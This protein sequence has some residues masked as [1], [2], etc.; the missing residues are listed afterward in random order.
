MIT[1][2]LCKILPVLELEDTPKYPRHPKC[3]GYSYETDCG[4]EYDCEYEPE[5]TCEDCMYMSENEGQGKDPTIE[6][7]QS[8]ESEASTND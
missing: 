3:G 4:T 6:V 1:F 5:L 2:T 8:P 7:R